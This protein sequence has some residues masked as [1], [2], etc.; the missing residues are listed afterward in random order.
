M[1]LLIFL[2]YRFGEF[3]NENKF[4]LFYY[5]YYIIFFCLL[6]DSATATAPPQPAKSTVT[7]PLFRT[8]RRRRIRADT[9]T[10]AS[11]RAGIRRS[12]RR[13]AQE[14]LTGSVRRA[15][16]AFLP[17]FDGRSGAY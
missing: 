15:R 9:A 16:V 7:N 4:A 1:Y 13:G 5:Y 8:D 10:T 11:W 6:L 2:F 12:G 17:V 3:R 14:A